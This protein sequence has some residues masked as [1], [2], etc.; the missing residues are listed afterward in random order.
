MLAHTRER[1]VLSLLCGI[2][3]TVHAAAVTGNE[4]KQLPLPAQET[5]VIGVV[6]TWNSLEKLRL[7]L[8]KGSEEASSIVTPLV[9][10]IKEKMTYGQMIAIVQKYIGDNP[11]HWH[12]DMPSIIRVAIHE[13]CTSTEQKRK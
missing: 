5:Y 1:M 3:F 7:T 2:L 11:A 6:D 9:N 4:W 10:C 12:Y 13:A 8:G